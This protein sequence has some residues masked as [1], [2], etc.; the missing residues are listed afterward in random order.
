MQKE[1]KVICVGSPIIDRLAH[2]GENALGRLGGGKG[3]MLLVETA[4]MKILLNDLREPVAVSPGG[5]A[6]NTAFALSRLAVPSVILGKVGGDGLGRF[7][8]RSFERVGGDSSRIKVCGKSATASCLCLITPDSERTMRTDLG[9]A[10]GL[11]P[12]EVSA[13]DFAGCRHAHVEGYLL[14][15]PALAKSVLSA[16]REAGCTVS[17]D[18]GSYEVVNANADADALPGLLSEYVDVVMANE[19]EAA[20]F[21]GSKDPL[22]GLKALSACVP[23]AA[24]KLGSRG[25]CIKTNKQSLFVAALP[26]DNPVDATGAGDFWAAGFLYGRLQGYSMEDSGRF[27]AVLGAEAVCHLGANLPAEAWENIADRF[28]AI[29]HH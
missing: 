8:R 13:E 28:A 22:A 19:D 7:Y 3:G 11:L 21:C 14:F 29:K 17:L 12:G 20:A 23:V 25:A 26:V 24:V 2:V 16:A 1:L 9:A 4:A 15:N 5:S 18:L 6:A 10:G 27:G